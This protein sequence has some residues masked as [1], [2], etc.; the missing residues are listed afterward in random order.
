MCNLVHFFLLVMYNEMP[1]DYNK[2]VA[3]LI[4]D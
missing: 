1:S 2:E 3:F 4:Y